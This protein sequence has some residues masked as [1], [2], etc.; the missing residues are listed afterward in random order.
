MTTYTSIS[1]A[2]VAVGAKP[3]ATTIQALRDNP[4]SIAEGTTGSPVTAAGWHPYNSTINGT[5]NGV[6]YDFAISG[7]VTTVTSPDFADGYEYMFVFNAITVGATGGGG[8]TINLYRE[9]SAAYAGTTAIASHPTLTTNSVR[10][11]CEVLQPR[12]TFQTV[13]GR[14]QSYTGAVS[15]SVG[16]ATPGGFYVAHATAQK[17]LRAQFSFGG[18]GF[19]FTGG[20][21]TM[22]RRKV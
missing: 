8:L 19:N 1:N 5:G 17:V 11:Y 20:T 2:L 21:I 9:T 3:F 14:Y 22:Y 12:K 7:A 10:G 16:T 18:G 15:N 6:I 13:F 4:L